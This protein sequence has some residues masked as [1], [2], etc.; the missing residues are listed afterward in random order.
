MEQALVTATQPPYVKLVRNYD[1]ST[2][3]SLQQSIA[4]EIEKRTALLKK[5]IEARKASKA[6][7]EL[8]APT[9]RY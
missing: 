3:T 2:V 9:G 5:V 6:C 7:A 1:R 8:L 4:D